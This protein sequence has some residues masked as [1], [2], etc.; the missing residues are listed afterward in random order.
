[1]AVAFERSRAG[2]PCGRTGSLGREGE[3]GI[4]RQRKPGGFS[5]II[6]IHCHYT[7]TCRPAEPG[8]RFSFEAACENDDPVL[9]SCISPRALRRPVWRLSKRM[10]GLDPGLGPGSELDDALA[11]FYEAHHACPNPVDRIVLLAF[12]KYHDDQGRRP[13]LPNSRTERG[14]DI[15]TS[16]SLVRAVCRRYPERYLFGASVHPYRANAVACIEEVYREGASLLKWIPLHQNI[17]IT[18]TRTLDVMRCC[19]RLGLPILVHYSGE[20]TLAT[21]HREYHSI[22]PLLKALRKLRDEDAIPVTIVPHVATPVAPW[23]E[24]RSHN[25]LVKALLGEFADAPLYADISALTSWGK[26]GFL[27]KLAARQDLHPKLLFGTDFPI[28]CALPRLRRD[29]SNDYQR[30]R[31]EPSWI[32]QA[33]QVFR[34]MKFNEIV[35]HRA[36]ELLPNVHYFDNAVTFE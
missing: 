18:D 15:Y 35:F 9:D 8:E 12:D 7:F 32:R 11:K 29:L 22:V 20:F 3:A 34:R 4:I 23:G 5:M 16:N 36:G 1:M 14:S 33:I 30:I 13:G 2:E 26:V 28:P 19:A 24:R 10:L 31:N 17:D 27:R 21:Q 6:D 25:A